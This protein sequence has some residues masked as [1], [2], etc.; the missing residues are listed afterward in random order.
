[1]ASKK[2][3]VKDSERKSII[4]PYLDKCMICGS[5]DR[6]AI[7]E[8]F[9][10]AANR[11]KS[12]EDYMCVPLCY[13]HHNGSNFGVHFNKDLDNKLKVQAEKI[14]IDYYTDSTLLYEKRIKLFIDRYGKNYLD[15]EL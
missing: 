6:V 3:K 12:K 14:W 8:V 13:Y 1:M 4:V 7:H 5:S 15:E 11:K 10:G 9:F 2:D